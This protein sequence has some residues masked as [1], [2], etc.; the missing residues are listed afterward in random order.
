MAVQQLYWEDVE[1]GAA[2]TPLPKIATTEM[3]VKW[4]GAS[5]DLNPL[6]Y[7]DAFA[8]AQGQPTVIVHGQ[9][10]RAWL[11]HLMTDWIGPRGVLKKL[12]CQFRGTDIPRGM[13]MVSMPKDGET[14]YC[15]GTVT[16]KYVEG[17]DHLV[18][19]EIWVENGSGEKTT[20]GSATAALPSR[21]TKAQPGKSKG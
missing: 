21:G 3:L 9:L 13:V 20:P 15:K 11:A 17:D 16:K 18:D 14:W 4:A 19:C 12:G 6:H 1:E 2:V 5:G 7:E 8:K 10:K